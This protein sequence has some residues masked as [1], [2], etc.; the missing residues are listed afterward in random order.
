MKSVAVIP[1][2]NEGKYI[3]DTVKHAKQYVDEVIVVD[4]NSSD[5]TYTL[6]KQAG[7]LV[8]QHRMNLGKASATKTGC[9]TAYKRKAQ[10]II[11]IDGDGQHNPD[12]IPN[13]LKSFDD[14]TD[15]VFG[16]RINTKSMPLIRKLGTKSL[17]Y[18][19]KWLFHVNIR[20]MQ[21][22]YRA[23]TSRVYPILRWKSKN[24]HADA[25]ITA[26][27]GKNKLR[28][29]EI[30]IETIYHDSYKGMTIIDGV[31]LLIKLLIWKI[32]L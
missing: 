24:Y 31:S 16:S 14:E 32:K 1:A 20:D 4:D 10:I 11:L 5:D 18:S 8:L 2:Y 12:E 19:M 29:K 13:F 28:Y 3:S 9:E 30:P 15:I 21:C 23:F 7:A 25:E 27:V 26:R 22:G 6:A 17:E